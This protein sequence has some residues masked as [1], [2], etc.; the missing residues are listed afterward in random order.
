[1]SKF[2]EKQVNTSEI[3]A[4]AVSTIENNI[5]VGNEHGDITTLRIY[6]ASDNSFLAKSSKM[7]KTAAPKIETFMDFSFQL[8]SIAKM[9][10]NTEQNT[11]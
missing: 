2:N 1:M 3:T 10:G 4:I 6:T 7:L 8:L 11:L 9:N 5:Y